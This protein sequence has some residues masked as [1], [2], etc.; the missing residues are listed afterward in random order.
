MATRVAALSSAF[1]KIKLLE[2]WRFGAVLGFDETSSQWYALHYEAEY[3]RAVLAE[4]VFRD[5]G[6]LAY[7]LLDRPPSSLSLTMN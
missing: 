5:L 4:L 2:E 7:M 6:S 3:S 1:D